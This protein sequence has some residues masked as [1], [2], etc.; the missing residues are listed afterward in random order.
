MPTVGR[1][2]LVGAGMLLVAAL[3]CA[4]WGVV[5]A[6]MDKYDDDPYAD[7]HIFKMPKWLD[8]LGSSFGI[9]CSIVA[10]FALGWLVAEYQAR[11][12]RSEWGTICVLLSLLGIGASAGGRVVTDATNGANIG[13][14]LILFL[15]APTALIIGITWLLNAWSRLLSPPGVVA[16]QDHSQGRR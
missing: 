3:T 10:A 5:G 16:N 15:V 1:K 13:G 12:W 7:S 6:A 14:G 2:R 4:T 9:V 8:E 11:R